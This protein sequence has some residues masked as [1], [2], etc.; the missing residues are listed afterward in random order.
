MFEFS[1]KGEKLSIKSV[2]LVHVEEAEEYRSFQHF[3]A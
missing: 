2:S 1:T 3:L